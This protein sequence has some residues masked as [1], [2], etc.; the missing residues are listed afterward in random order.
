VLGEPAGR[1]RAGQAARA[2]AGA[3]ARPGTQGRRA[4]AAAPPA[5]RSRPPRPT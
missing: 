1:P 5:A 3:G 4:L 2:C